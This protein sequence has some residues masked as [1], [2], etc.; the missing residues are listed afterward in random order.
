[1][2]FLGIDLGW[3]GKPSG[4]AQLHW[5]GKRLHLTSI[6]RLNSHADLLGAV[7]RLDSTRPLWIGLD[8]PVLI[9]NQSGMRPVDRVAHELF[10]K[11]RAG[12][13]PVHLGMSFAPN[14]LPFVQ[15]LKDLGFSTELPSVRQQP[16]RHLFEVYPHSAAVRL[17]ALDRILPYKKGKAADRKQA[18]TAFRSLLAGGLANRRPYF[19]ARCL[20]EPGLTL[21][22]LKAC[23]DQLDAVLCAYIAAHFWYWGLARNNILGEAES[24]WIVNPSF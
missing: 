16:T 24:G 6:E 8:A 12:C 1:M 7:A 19:E 17:F 4:L 9:R 5:D 13:Y 18:L 23:E 3:T 14:V 10:S 20:P 22:E 2:I 11:E 15:G 21:A